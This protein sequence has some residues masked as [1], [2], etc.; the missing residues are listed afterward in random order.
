M[1]KILHIMIFVALELAICM[2]HL[3]IFLNDLSIWM[4]WFL[5]NQLTRSLER[6]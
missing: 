1:A 3:S 4:N 6:Q 2:K 5:I